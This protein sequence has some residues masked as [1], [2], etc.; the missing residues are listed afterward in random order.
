MGDT[1]IADVPA[2]VPEVYDPSAVPRR[3]SK[4]TLID[5][6]EAAGLFQAVLD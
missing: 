6:L 5:R 3:L 4:L 1:I 2:F